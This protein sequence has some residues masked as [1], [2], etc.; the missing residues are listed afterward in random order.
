MNFDIMAY[1]KDRYSYV[2]SNTPRV[3][4]QLGNIFESMT[5][6]ANFA[7]FS[8]ERHRLGRE[9][10]IFAF[11]RSGFRDTDGFRFIKTEHFGNSFSIRGLIDAET[12]P[13]AVQAFW[14]EGYDYVEATIREDNPV[15]AIPRTGL[16]AKF[17]GRSEPWSSF[18]KLVAK[19]KGRKIRVYTNSKGFA[20]Q[21]EEITSI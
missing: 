19:R 11:N 7:Y 2:L 20:S 16:A 10:R 21:I 18:T 13:Y 6:L 5:D 3:R 8:Q 9:T 4:Q 1:Q 15:T 17:G 14:K 12:I